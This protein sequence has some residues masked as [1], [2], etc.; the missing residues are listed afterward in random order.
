M[1]I[2]TDITVSDADK[3]KDFYTQ[4]FGWTVEEVAMEDEV[5]SYVD[6]AMVDKDGNGV[7]GICNK[8]SVN[9]DLPSQWIVYFTVRDAQKSVET[10]LKLGGNILKESRNEDGEIFYA[11][12]EDPS[13]AVVAFMQEEP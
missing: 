1:G 2:W 4:V 13:G 12:I 11:L 3:L 8:R 10:C 7:G 9:K 6:Y 5:G